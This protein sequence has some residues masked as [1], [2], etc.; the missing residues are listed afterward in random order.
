VRARARAHTYVHLK[1]ANLSAV[2]SYGPP[3]QSMT[4]EGPGTGFLMTHMGK[5]KQKLTQTQTGTQTQTQTQTRTQTQ[6]HKYK[7]KREQKI[8]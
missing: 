6:K 1:G 2:G 8:H 3:N 5:R 4:D 7:H